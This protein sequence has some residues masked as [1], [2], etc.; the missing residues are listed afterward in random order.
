MDRSNVL[1]L[2]T[3]TYTEDNLKQ[4]IPTETSRKV[5]C[6][7][8]SVSQSE[9]FEAGRNGLKAAFQVTMFAYDYHGEQECLYGGVRYSIYRTYRRQDDDIELYL[10]KR[11]GSRG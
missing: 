6:D 7:V 11:V 10:E 1:Y 4:R 3:K 2:L 8:S 9:F 5:F